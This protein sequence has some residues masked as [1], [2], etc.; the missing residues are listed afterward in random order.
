M[1]IN[2]SQGQTL[3]QVLVYLPHSCFS[4]GQLYVALSRARTA[5]KIKVL[6]VAPTIQHAQTSVKNVVS[7]TVLRVIR[8]GWGTL[9]GDQIEAFEETLQYLVEYDIYAATIKFIDEKLRTDLDQFPY[10]MTFVSRTVF[11]PVH[12]DF[13][14]VLPN[15][16]QIATIPRAVDPDER[17]G[18]VL[19]VEEEPRKVEGRDKGRERLVRETIIT[20]QRVNLFNQK[21]LDRQAMVLD[22]K[23]SSENKNIVSIAELKPKKEQ[24]LSLKPPMAWEEWHS[25]H[26]TMTQRLLRKSA[27]EIYAI[28]EENSE[29]FIPTPNLKTNSMKPS[30]QETF[31]KEPQSPQ[32]NLES[33]KLAKSLGKRLIESEVPQDTSQLVL[34][35]PTVKKKLHF[36]RMTPQKHTKGQSLRESLEK[37]N[38]QDVSKP[39]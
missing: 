29:P 12:P 20:D 2:K 31:T 39:T 1:T 14:P 24:H 34:S 5:D 7:Y 32:Q 21:V 28:K 6:S 35:Q 11:Q 26:S 33:I 37:D 23:Y 19:Y 15:Y 22:V 17:Y 4:H 27:A 36:G 25:P 38:V 13:G 3:D 10:Q 8:C 18:V 9:F 30:Q 16:Q